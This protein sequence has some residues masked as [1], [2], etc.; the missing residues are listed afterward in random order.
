MKLPILLT[1]EIRATMPE[2]INILHNFGN[3]DVIFEA[4]NPDDAPMF[5]SG[6]NA[7][8]EGDK[9]EIIKWLKPFDGVPIGNGSP[10]LESFKIMHI[11]DDL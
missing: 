8:I 5:L 6:D 4:I 10:Q 9:E 2:T 1:D 7:V 11:K 3:I